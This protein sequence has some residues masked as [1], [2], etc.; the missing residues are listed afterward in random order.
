MTNDKI[1]SFSNPAFHDELTDLV[2]SGARRIIR[3]AVEEELRSFL[4]EHGSDRDAEEPGPW[5]ATATCLSAR[6]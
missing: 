1:V 2:R 6:Y 3:Q 4:D 5:F